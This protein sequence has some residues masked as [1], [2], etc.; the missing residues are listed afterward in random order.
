MNKCSKRKGCYCASLHAVFL[1]HAVQLAQKSL[2]IFLVSRHRSLS[3]RYEHGWRNFPYLLVTV[4][5]STA[6]C[7]LSYKTW[8]ANGNVP[9]KTLWSRKARESLFCPNA[10]CQTKLGPCD[11]KQVSCSISGIFFFHFVYRLRFNNLI[12]YI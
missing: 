3:L 1:Q 4:S 2:L 12:S 9:P 11:T 8:V 10:K 6:P 7:P 5:P